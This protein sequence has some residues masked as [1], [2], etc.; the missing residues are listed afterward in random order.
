MLSAPE[1]VRHAS[2][3]SMGTAWARPVAPDH[4][5]TCLAG[6]FATRAQAQAVALWLRDVQGM[7]PAEQAVLGPAHAPSRSFRRLARSWSRGPDAEGRRWQ[8]D[9][10]LM[11]GLGALSFGLAAAIALCVDGSL[12]DGEGAFATLAMP[13]FGLAGGWAAARWASEVSQYQRF[14]QSVREQ[15][16]AGHWAVVVHDVPWPRQAAVHA[17]MQQ[18]RFGWCSAGTARSPL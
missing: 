18:A 14:D 12:A 3:P 4:A 17:Q 16:V 10:P 2:A 11:A 5:V 1:H 13:L 6:F 9:A 7:G 8:S 15:L